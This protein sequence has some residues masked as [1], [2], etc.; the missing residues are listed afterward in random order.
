M[1]ETV[2]EMGP[3]HVAQLVSVIPIYQICRFDLQSRHV[4][5]STNEYTDKWNNK[6]MSL[7]PLPLS[8]ISTN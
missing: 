4:Q 5:E 1:V 8:L 2:Y 6:S 3:G 7:S